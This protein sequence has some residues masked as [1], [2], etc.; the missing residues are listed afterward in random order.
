MTELLVACDVYRAYVRPGRPADAE[1]TARIARG[2]RPGR[3]RPPGP[4]RRDRPA[5]RRG[6]ATR[7]RPTTTSPTSPCG[8]QQTWG[9]VMAKGI[10]DTAFYRWHRLLAL[11]EVGG[12]P[13]TARVGRPEAAARVG[14]APAGALAARHDHAVHPRHQAQRGRAGP[15]PRARRRRRVVGRCAREAFARGRPTSTAS[16]GPRRTCS[17]RPWSAPGDSA[18]SGSRRTS[19]RP[20]A[21]PSSTPPGSTATR[22]TRRRSPRLGGG[23]P[24]ARPPPCAGRDRA[25]PPGRRSGPPSLGQKLLQLTV[26]GVPDTYQGCEVVRPLPGRPRQPPAG[27]LRRACAPGSTTSP[28]TALRDLDDEKL[29][30]T[31]RALALRKEL[32]HCFGD[33]GSYQPGRRPPPATSWASPA[34]S[35]VA[36]LVTRAARRLE[37]GGGWATPPPPRCPRACGATC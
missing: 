28:S 34:A 7:P 8:F 33:A 1:A 21:R 11:N 35:E 37:A 23:R 16:T 30:V 19:P 22:T 2:T 6:R 18:P 13:A 12:D 26:P 3:R 32:R 20:P 14:G 25:R 29:L 36:V 27:R 17:G 4:R 10:E 9:P 24:R 31:S 15:D 5:G